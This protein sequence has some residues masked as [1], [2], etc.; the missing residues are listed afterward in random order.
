MKQLLKMLEE[1][2]KKIWTTNKPKDVERMRSRLGAK[3]QNYTIT[4]YAVGGTNGIAD[5]LH[6]MRLS[7]QDKDADVKT[8]I[9][10]T[11]NLLSFEASSFV[12]YYNLEDTSKLMEKTVDVLKKDVKTHKDFLE[13][14]E[15][16]MR[17]LG[18]LNY[19]ID[20]EMPWKELADEY[21]KLKAN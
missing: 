4:D 8:L 6:C 11:C 1:E 16:L 12:R 2:R 15:A 20:L 17:Y 18:K 3:E 14:I 19:W 10:A 21:E 7:A 9:L 13:V 5:F